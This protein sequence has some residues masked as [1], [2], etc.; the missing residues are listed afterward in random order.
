MDTATRI[1]QIG[2]A[3][4]AEFARGLRGSVHRPGDP[5]Y[6]EA[7]TVWNAAHD[8]RP[9]LVVR[10]AGVADVIRTV[11]LARTEGV[12]LAVRGGGHSVAGF[13]TCDDGI[14][15]DLSSMR[16]IRVDASRR[17]AIAQGG[18]VWRDLDIETQQFGLAVTGG[19]VSSTGIAGFTLG[20]GIG[21][22]SR[23]CGVAADSLV[24]ADVVTADGH[25]VRADEGQHHELWWALRGGGGNFGVV[26]ALE[27]RLHN[28][29]TRVFAGVTLYPAEEARE[30]L[31]G[32]AR[33][34][35]GGRDELT[36]IAKLTTA[37]V[38]PFVPVSLQGTPVVLVSGC[39]SGPAEDGAGACER[40]RSLGT[41]LTDT[42]A[43][44]DYVQ[45][46]RALDT[47]FPRGMHNYFSGRFLARL[48]DAAIGR[49]VEAFRCA[50]GAACEVLVHQ[51]GGAV[52][53][54]PPDATAFAVRHHP[55]L[56]N[57]IAR[58]SVGDC[59]APAV[60]WAKSLANSLGPGAATY[61]NF[62]GDGDPVLAQRSYPPSTLARLVAVKDRYD[63]GNLF[64]LN[65]NIQPSSPEGESS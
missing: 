4:V 42:Y 23:R 2:E 63:P 3:T 34:C 27:Y 55:Y 29:G 6:D 35:A 58:T 13:S 26:T 61:V 62:T 36:T 14:V 31:A 7:R 15:L 37:P 47:L 1:R 21:W 25:V 54:V 18:C 28:I 5:D 46:Q 38:L 51:L 48:D 57:V 10:C 30:V 40:F 43:R 65:Q 44:R 60:A 33:A 64:R 12:P 17:R 24:A 8:R 49:A 16:G 9:A 39:W 50:P 20:G 53:D 11:Q 59:F 32:Y 22:L 41:V 56:V 52:A 45:W 19:L